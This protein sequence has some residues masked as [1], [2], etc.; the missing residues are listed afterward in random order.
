[1][2]APFQQVGNLSRATGPVKR[3]ADIGV[4]LSERAQDR[5]N[6]MEDS[7]RR[8]PYVEL[9]DAAVREPPHRVDSII[10]LAQGIAG[11][12]EKVLP[13]NRQLH[14]PGG[15]LQQLTAKAVFE[16]PYVVAE[17][18]LLHPQPLRRPPEMKLL[19]DS[20]E[21]SEITK[22]NRSIHTSIRL[23]MRATTDDRFDSGLQHGLAPV[24][25][26]DTMRLRSCA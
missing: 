6:D 19:S 20:D 23:N 9:A 25:P 1:M 11:S 21:Q 18:R 2:P 10:C 13:G 26:S 5:W 4:T 7:G 22:L 15:S 3:Q 16:L 8:E 12:F 17:M 14:G 24:G